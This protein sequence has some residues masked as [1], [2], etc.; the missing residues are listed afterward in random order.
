MLWFPDGRAVVPLTVKGFEE[1][2]EQLARINPR[3]GQRPW[4]RSRLWWWGMWVALAVGCFVY[5]DSLYS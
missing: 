2:D 1:L 4:F 5:V 3:H